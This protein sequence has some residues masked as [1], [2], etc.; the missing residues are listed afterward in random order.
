ML[1]NV[2]FSVRPLSG[3]LYVGI[4]VDYNYF[5]YFINDYCNNFFV[6]LS[7]IIIII[8]YL[9]PCD[10]FGFKDNEDRCRCRC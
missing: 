10:T 1:L 8:I 7:F 5:I 9:H 3:W 6:Y 2:V 4:H